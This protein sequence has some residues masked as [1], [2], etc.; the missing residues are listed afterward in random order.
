MPQASGPRVIVVGAGVV[1]CSL[2]FHLA[3]SG[4]RGH[5]VRPRR[6]LRRDVGALGRAGRMHYTFAPEAELAWKSLATSGTGRGSSAG[7]AVLSHRLRRR[8]RSGERGQAAGERRDAASSR[9]RYRTCDR[10]SCERSSPPCAST[11][12]G[13]PPTSLTAATRTRSRQ[14]RR[15]RPR[16]KARRGVLINTAIAAPAVNAGRGVGVTDRSGNTH[17]A[18]SV[19]VITGPWTDVLLAPLGLKIGIKPER[20]QIAF[21]EAADCAPLHL[22]RYDCR[23]LLSSARR[24]SHDGGAWRLESGHA[25]R[26]RFIQRN[27]RCGIYRGGA[28][29]PRARGFPR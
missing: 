19:C 28:H 29:A 7:D 9:R 26:S 22:Y 4:A 20:A 11:T 24:R 17:E 15:S 13:W 3:H 6:S 16:R 23:Q 18:D 10:G 1:G 14:P 5:G 21:F 2:A 8:G 27:Q 12:S 25:D